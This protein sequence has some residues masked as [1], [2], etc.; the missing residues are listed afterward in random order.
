MAFYILF[1]NI[2]VQVSNAQIGLN[3]LA[4][5]DKHCGMTM[6]CNTNFHSLARESM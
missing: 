4:T 6:V 1:Y 5:S 2:S 3:D